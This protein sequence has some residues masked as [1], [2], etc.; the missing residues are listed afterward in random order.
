[1]RFC[2]CFF[3]IYIGFSQWV[4]LINKFFFVGVFAAILALKE[5]LMRS[6]ASN[7]QPILE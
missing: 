4:Y 3:F 5:E 6:R 2:F 7:V 1:M